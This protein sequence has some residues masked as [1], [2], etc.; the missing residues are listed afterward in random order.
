M[1][2]LSTGAPIKTHPLYA[3]APQRA[4]SAP[5]GAPGRY[6]LPRNGNLPSEPGARGAALPGDRAPY[7]TTPYPEAPYGAAAGPGGP[8]AGAP[9]PGAAQA[10][11]P[12]GPRQYP[13]GPQRRHFQPGQQLAVVG[14]QYILAGDLFPMVN[15]YMERVLSSLTPEQ[16]E[17]ISPEQIEEQ[18]D[19]VLRKYLEL[20][21]EQKLLFVDFRRT[22]ARNAKDKVNEM[23]A[24]IQ[25]KVD[26]EFE[27]SQVDQ[28]MNMLGVTTRSELDGKLRSYGSSLED[29]RRVFL[30]QAL[31]QE[32]LKR[33]TQ[34]LPEITYA[35]LRRRYQQDIETYTVAAK[36]KWEQ[37]TVLFDQFESKEQAWNALADMGN[38]VRF[39]ASLAE[40]ATQGSQ[41]AAASRGGFHDWTSQGSLVSEEIDSAIFSLPPNALSPIIEDARGYH[42]VRVLDRRE[43]GFV[44]FSEAQ[45]EIEKTLRNERKEKQRTEYLARL[46][47]EIPVWTIFDGQVASGF[48]SETR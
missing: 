2:V 32:M 26:Q 30:E 15:Q 42:I 35:D 43:A 47:S 38:R 8:Y 37:L 31:G 7:P 4:G 27:K 6:P 23:F 20:T 9:G 25:K 40:V 33:N 39:G 28:L 18:R 45:E 46:R 44:P 29:R 11:G 1:V 10:V 12:D 3:Q 22:A 19:V 24:D 14:D 17:Q 13:F 21:I 41:E 36:A 5:P 48:R 16:R 34:Q